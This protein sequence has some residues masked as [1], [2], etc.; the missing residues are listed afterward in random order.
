MKIFIDPL[1]GV[2][3]GLSDTAEIAGDGFRP[4]EMNVGT[5]G[6]FGVKGLDMGGANDLYSRSCGQNVTIVPGL[7]LHVA[8]P[9]VATGHQFFILNGLFGLGNQPREKLQG[10]DFQG[11]GVVP[12]DRC[13]G[14]AIPQ[15]SIV[16]VG[17]GDKR[18]LVALFR[19]PLE[20]GN[21]G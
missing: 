7:L 21:I 13:A 8:Y 19:Q 18:P 4:P 16:I 2:I 14:S 11:H 10:T 6:T 20:L 1:V 5:I 3:V 17:Q 9:D 12:A 15:N